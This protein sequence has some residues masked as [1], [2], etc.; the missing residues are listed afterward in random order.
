MK[1]SNWKESFVKKGGVSHL[2]HQLIDLNTETSLKSNL[3]YQSVK[4][5]LE[6]LLEFA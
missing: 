2:L 5:L 3:C 1:D 6:T 4:L